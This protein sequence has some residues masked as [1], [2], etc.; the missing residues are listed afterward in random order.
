MLG[1]QKAY[2]QQHTQLIQAGYDNPDPREIFVM[3]LTKQIQQWQQQKYEILLCMDANENMARI[4]P[5]QGIGRLLHATGLIDLHKH[6][7][8]RRPTPPTYNRGTTTIDTCLGSPLFAQALQAAW[9][10]P[11][12]H[13]V[14]LPGDHRLLGLAFDIDILFGHKLPDPTKP[15]Q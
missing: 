13:P 3:D 8:P 10:L 14:T 11:F 2:T 4:S 15:Q 5:T 9:Y 1:S 12:G 6:R 7:Q